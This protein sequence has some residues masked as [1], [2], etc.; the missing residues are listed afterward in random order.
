[1]LH[2]KKTDPELAKKTRR[3]FAQNERDKEVTQSPDVK[4]IDT[5]RKKAE[6]SAPRMLF[7][8]MRDTHFP[9]F[10]EREDE[11]LKKSRDESAWRTQLRSDQIDSMKDGH[12][13]KPPLKPRN[14]PGIDHIKEDG[15]DSSRVNPRSAFRSRTNKKALDWRSHATST[16]LWGDKKPGLGGGS[17]LSKDHALSTVKNHINQTLTNARKR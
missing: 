13:Y 8:L 4:K 1:L 11:K 15:H 6:H 7:K 14:H 16:S 5:S 10:K 3:V 12:L 9:K 2:D 17:S